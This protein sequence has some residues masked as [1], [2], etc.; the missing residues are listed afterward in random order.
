MKLRKLAAALA[1]ASFLL[2]GTDATAATPAFHLATIYAGQGFTG[3]S[4]YLTWSSTG[5]CINGSNYNW[6]AAASP[7]A[8][9]QALYDNSWGQAARA[10][11]NSSSPYCNRVWIKSGPWN[12]PENYLYSTCLKFGTGIS[13]F[14][15]PYDRNVKQFGLS[16]D[17]ACPR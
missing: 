13:I 17:P 4:H 5:N 7:P 11:Y 1:A 9:Q 6:Y 3:Q 14:G 12:G 10:F 8:I 15:Y 2:A 16:N